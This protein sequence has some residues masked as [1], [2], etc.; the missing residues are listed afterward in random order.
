MTAQQHN[1]EANETNLL[2][3][4]TIHDVLAI[5][6]RRFQLDHGSLPEVIHLNSNCQMSFVV[7]LIRL[8]GLEPEAAV[9]SPIWI[10]GFGK[11]I[12]LLYSPVLG[13][14]FIQLI[15]AR[16]GEISTL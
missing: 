9:L 1:Y 4:G 11:T 14:V 6:L 7:E 5:Q 12:P 3:H 15:N 2:A 10:E 16:L 13:D 8:Q